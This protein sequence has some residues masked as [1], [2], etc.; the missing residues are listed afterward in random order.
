MTSVN[1]TAIPN[2]NLTWYTATTGNLGLDFNLWNQKLTGTL[3]A[4][5]RTRDGL[6]RTPEVQLPGSVGATMPQQNIESDRT[7]GWEVT[8]GHRNR[9]QGITYW[10]NGQISATKNRWVYRLD[11]P[12]GNSM[13]NWYRQD[14]GA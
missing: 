2:P 4:F 12:A 1:P 11:S 3:E 7:F 8:L 6:L 9:W 10:I 14:V 5:R 13:E